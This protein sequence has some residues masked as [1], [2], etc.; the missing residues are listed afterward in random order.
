MRLTAWM[1]RLLD[2][3]I[4]ARQVAV[5]RIGVG[6][7]V[8]MGLPSSAET[9]PRLANP[10]LLR[11]PYVGWFPDPDPPVVVVLLVAWAVSAVLFMVGW[12]TR[13]AGAVLAAT[14]ASVLFIDQ[15]MYN[16]YL[17]LMVLSVGL[18]TLADS[19]AA[20]SVDARGRR[21]PAAIPAWPILLLCVQVS[22]VYGFAALA[23]LNID[24]VAGSVVASYLR[25]DGPLAVPDA[26]RALEPMMMLSVLGIFSEAF[27]A[28]A[29]WSRRWRPAAFV[30]GLG[31]HIG[32][33]GWL[34][35]TNSLFVFSILMFALFF[36]FLEVPPAGRVVVWDDGCGFCATWVRWFRRLDWTDALRF[37]PLSALAA[38]DLPVS[39]QAAAEALHLVSPSGGVR[40]GFSAVVG[41]AEVLPLSFLWAPIFRLPPL[42]AVGD[43]V[44]RRVAAR[45]TC[46]IPGLSPAQ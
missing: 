14:I 31:L 18:L 13:V 41:V 7:A 16:N 11:V 2:A 1:S 3:R 45:R 22:I 15:Q 26:W 27:L 34:V 29:L 38:S 32:I 44:Y 37:V 24:Y 46:P 39:E 28:V 9:L 25:R 33:T 6:A 36:L 12:R 17:Y 8:L 42:A 40:S 4:N 20:I 30:L 21:T 43:R 10:A 19:G 5:A 35:S 23:K